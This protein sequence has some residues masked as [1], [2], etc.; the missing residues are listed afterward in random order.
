MSK[1]ENHIDVC[2]VCKTGFECKSLVKLR[3]IYVKEKFGDILVQ[4]TLENGTKMSVGLYD[5][6]TQS[7]YRHSLEVKIEGL[8]DM[9]F[10]PKAVQ[11]LEQAI[12]K[13]L[14]SDNGCG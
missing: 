13:H 14:H 2:D 12:N 5:H 9:Y 4:G 1:L 3:D 11:I 7:N 6:G 8:R 10:S